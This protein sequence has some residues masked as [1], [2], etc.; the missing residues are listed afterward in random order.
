MS[1]ASLTHWPFS[2]D[3]QLRS[4][5]FEVRSLPHLMKAM[6]W[7]KEP[8]LI[9]E[10]LDVYEHLTDLNDRRRRDAEVIAAACCN[11]PAKHILEIG[12]AAG[13]TTALMAVNAPTA[14]VHTVNIPPEDIKQGGSL[15]TY[16]PSREEIG[17]HYRELNLTNVAQIYANTASW[18][19]D[20]G[21]IDIALIDGCHDKEFVFNDTRIVLERSRPGTII[22]WHDFSP[23]ARRQFAWIDQVTKG[24]AML[25]KDRILSG[26]VYHV[27]DSWIGLHVVAKGAPH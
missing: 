12:T 26:P 15:T 19:P 2:I 9:G 6:G 25:F 7:T 13:R 5:V 17:R 18:K 21:P 24:V 10:H 27:Q 23:S 11:H 1:W 3:R 8:T 22:L 14:T 4:R 16:A 20:F